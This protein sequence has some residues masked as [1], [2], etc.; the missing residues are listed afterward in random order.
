[1][2]EP[3]PGR[4]A[5]PAERRTTGYLGLRLA[6]EAIVSWDAALHGKHGN[7]TDGT[8]PRAWPPTWSRSRPASGCSALPH[9]RCAACW[10]CSRAFSTQPGKSTTKRRSLR[11]PQ[12]CAWPPRTVPCRDSPSRATA[13]KAGIVGCEAQCRCRESRRSWPCRVTGS[14]HNAEHERTGQCSRPVAA[15]HRIDLRRAVTRNGSSPGLPW[16]PALGATAS[17][18]T[19]RTPREAQGYPGRIHD[20]H[21]APGPIAHR[22]GC[23]AGVAGQLRVLRGVQRMHRGPGHRGLSLIRPG[24]LC[25]TGTEKTS[26]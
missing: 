8:I 22:S 7:Q 13:I 12:P 18:G 5:N 24:N 6:V 11:W 4:L 10:W 15:G 1:M 21:P 23:H 25:I 26:G 16:P 19:P 20:F 2:A 9:A 3:D 17:S 14:A